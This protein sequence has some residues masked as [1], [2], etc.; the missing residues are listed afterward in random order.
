MTTGRAA[1]DRCLWGERSRRSHRPGPP[2]SPADLDLAD[3]VR[4]QVPLERVLEDVQR[5][6]IAE[7]LHQAGGDRTEAA[8]RLGLYRKRLDEKVVELGLE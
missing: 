7:A 1:C 8:R 2:L 5:R 4:R 6:M 3:L